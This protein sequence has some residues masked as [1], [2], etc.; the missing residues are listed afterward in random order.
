SPLPR[1]RPNPPRNG[2]ELKGGGS[3]KLDPADGGPSLEARRALGMSS[4]RGVYSLAS[5]KGLGGDRP[6][7]EW[8]LPP[9]S[10]V[11][12]SLYGRSRSVPRGGASRSSRNSPLPPSPRPLGPK[13]ADPPP[14][15]GP[16][17]ASFRA[18]GALDKS[19]PP[20]SDSLFLA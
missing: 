18:V 20:R 10:K 11:S 1:P 12:L 14:G 2:A 15:P 9:R 4:S 6:R 16:R 17:C 7:G 13:G 8:P 5:R 3:E 19:D